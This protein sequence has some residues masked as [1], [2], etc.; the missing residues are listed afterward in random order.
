MNVQVNKKNWRFLPLS[1]IIILYMCL[2]LLISGETGYAPCTTEGVGM[3]YVAYGINILWL[4]AL[5]R[6][7]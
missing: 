3:A 6:Y 7:Y 4:G 1:A 5:F 2:L